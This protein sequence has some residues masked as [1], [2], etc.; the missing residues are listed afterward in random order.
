MP[1][2]AGYAIYC[3][4]I[5]E[6]VS[7]QFSF[8]GVFRG[9]IVIA[10]FPALIPKLAIS[11]TWAQH[12]E[13]DR[14]PVRY[15]VIFRGDGD[16]DI[17]ILNEGDLPLHQQAPIEQEEALSI[18]DMHVRLSPFPVPKPGR[19]GVRLYRGEEEIR[20]RAL[21]FA[22]PLTDGEAPPPEG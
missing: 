3:E 22:A 1:Y 11:I 10:E 14:L 2:S 8:V 18:T 15:R 4:D 6:E 9:A 19:L 21:T 5:R 16:D 12:R 13:V 7:N 17:T 20:L